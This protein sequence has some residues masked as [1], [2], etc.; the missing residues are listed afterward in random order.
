MR[1]RRCATKAKATIRPRFSIGTSI[2]HVTLPQQ[3][4]VFQT[5]V[6]HRRPAT[7]WRSVVRPVVAIGRRKGQSNRNRDNGHMHR[8]PDRPVVKSAVAARQ[9]E[10]GKDL[11]YMLFISTSTAVAVL[12]LVYLFS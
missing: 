12:A 7:P 9:G 11:S 6:A 2:A 1:A 5:S 10:H 4:A 8:Y 3:T